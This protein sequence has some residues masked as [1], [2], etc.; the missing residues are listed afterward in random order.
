MNQGEA[1]RNRREVQSLALEL[2]GERVPVKLTVDPPTL[3]RW[4]SESGRRQRLLMLDVDV[5]VASANSVRIDFDLVFSPK[6][7]RRGTVVD[8]ADYYVGSTGAELHVQP[9]KGEVCDYTAG[10]SV[11]VNY[12]N[13]TDIARR[14]AATIGP[15]ATVSVGGGDT[16]LGIGNVSYAAGSKRA[17]SASFQAEERV[18]QTEFAN[19]HVKWVLVLP[20]GERAVRDFLQGNLSLY[21]EC[22]YLD[23]GIEG[24]IEVRPSNIRFF[25]PD[26]RPLGRM[27]SLRMRYALWNR[28]IRI[29]SQDPECIAFRV[30][31]VD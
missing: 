12:S 7:I 20:R 27:A 8:Q 15:E 11:D 4:L 25:G 19:P 24:Q 29:L 28:R 5:D 18:L 2:Q 3:V 13:S 16:K 21:A 10:R 31:K 23:R 14:S 22:R 9:R 17:M 30:N 26:R 1:R 6:S